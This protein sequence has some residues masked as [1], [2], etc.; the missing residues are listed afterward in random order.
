[1]VG[2]SVLQDN[3]NSSFELNIFTICLTKLLLRK[4]SYFTE[5]SYCK[6]KEIYL[7]S[8][9]ETIEKNTVYSNHRRSTIQQ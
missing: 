6:S 3:R 2:K 7:K 8:N 5:D 9:D 1:M 4:C